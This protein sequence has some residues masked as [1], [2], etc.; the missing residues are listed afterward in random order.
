MTKPNLLK[1]A[2][3]LRKQGYGIKTIAYKLKVSSST[4][5]R[6][7][8]NIIPTSEQ[9][10]ELKR[11]A[12]DPF[13]G[14]RKENILKQ[15][16]KCW[17]NINKLK[18]KG[19]KEVGKLNR[20]DLFISGIALYWAE[21]F[22]KDRR[23][24]F[25]NSDPDMIMIFLRWLTK[26]CHVPKE[27]IRLRV[28]LNISHKYRIQEVEDYWLKLTKI[29][30]DQFQKPFFQKFIWKKEYPQPEEYFGV[31][32]IRANKQLPLFRRIKGWIEGFKL[33]AKGP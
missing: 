8:N 6:W 17:D 32:R 4:V 24:G 9:L 10:D 19:I 5:S 13:Y 23:L 1:Q 33:N 2:Q 12:H 14:R 7:C 26:I 20:R 22:K 15:K 25:A 11:R 31:L 3:K 28:G 30:K 16:K 18:Q 21:G 29:P 27:S